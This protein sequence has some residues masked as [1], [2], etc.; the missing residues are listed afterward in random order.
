MVADYLIRHAMAKEVSKSEMLDN[1]SRSRDLRLVLTADNIKRQATFIC[2][3]CGCC[4]N[5]LLGVSKHGYPNFIVTTDYISRL[6][7]SK[8]TGCEQ[9]SKACP[10][11]AIE[12]VLDSELKTKSKKKPR[13]DESICLGCG[14][15]ALSCRTGAIRLTK[16]QK[17]VIYPETTFERVI[18]QSLDRGT[19][20]NQLFDNPGAISHKVMRGI[21]G[22]FTRLSPVKRA[23]MSNQLRSVF[24]ASMRTGARLQGRGI[25]TKM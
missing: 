6:D 12:M 1:I 21:I 18:L 14:V 17:R 15:C 9:C 19:L 16:R 23:M 3:C 13:V 5:L 2:H 7:E 25:L 20:Q 4:C 10:I 22:G 8:C 24:L 11:K